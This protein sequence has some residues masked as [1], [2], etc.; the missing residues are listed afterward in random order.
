[1]G[2]DVDISV[3][4]GV[5]VEVGVIVAVP[6][7]T[8]TELLPVR[9]MTK[10]TSAAP[11]IRNTASKPSAAGRLSVISGMRLACTAAGF[12]ASTVGLSSVPHTRQREALSARRVPQVGQIFVFEVDVVDSGLI[13]V[14]IIPC[15]KDGKG[16]MNKDTFI[17]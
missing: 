17:G 1:M 15:S 5:K 13:R 4:V 10:K 14:G 2:V 6:A 7:A 8:A 9:R 11:T 3:G 16:R 12:L